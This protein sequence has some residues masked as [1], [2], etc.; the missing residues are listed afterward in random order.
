MTT[1]TTT[2]LPPPT[3]TVL[4]IVPEECRSFGS[5]LGSPGQVLLEA[6][7]YDSAG[8]NKLLSVCWVD[9]YE[10]LNFG[11]AG[12]FVQSFDSNW[13]DPTGFPALF[14]S[15]DDVRAVV[16]EP[17]TWGMAVSAALLVLILGRRRGARK[18]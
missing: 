1:K 15:F 18:S 10:P 4:P 7:L 16:P 8:G 12:V 6:R 9:E 17:A 2:T 3:T 11:V 5:D 14:G 13:G